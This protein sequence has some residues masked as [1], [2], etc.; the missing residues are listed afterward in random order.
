MSV[1]DIKDIAG[2]SSLEYV[3]IHTDQLSQEDKNYILSLY[4]GCEIDECYIAN[5][6]I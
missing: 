6:D 2:F 5:L 3:R 1:K 4:P